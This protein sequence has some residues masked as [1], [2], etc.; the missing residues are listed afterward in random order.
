M[1]FNDE[2]ILNTSELEIHFDLM[3]NN[4][5]QNE[6]KKY[7]EQREEDED[8]DFDN[9]EFYENEEEKATSIKDVQKLKLKKIKVGGFNKDD[10]NNFWNEDLSKFD[11]IE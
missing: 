4:E 7:R 3:I 8:D 10:I 6:L 2:R 11:N 1:P 5:F 9:Y